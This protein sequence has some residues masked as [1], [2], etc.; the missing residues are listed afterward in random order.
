MEEKFCP[1][2][3]CS[4]TPAESAHSLLK[5]SCRPLLYN[6]C[7]SPPSLAC[8]ELMAAS[9]I[10]EMLCLPSVSVTT[11]SHKLLLKPFLNASV[12]PYSISPSSILSSLSLDAAGS[13]IQS[14]KRAEGVGPAELSGKDEGTYS[15]LKRRGEFC[16]LMSKGAMALEGERIMN[17]RCVWGSN[18]YL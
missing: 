15:D 4:K 1:T 7:F 5:T 9:L 11:Y 10:Q 13:S 14:L 12:Y 16:N 3:D 2:E 18:R 8:P 17:V 6:S